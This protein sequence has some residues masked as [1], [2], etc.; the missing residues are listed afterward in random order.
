MTDTTST[1]TDADTGADTGVPAA[2]GPEV[3]A[4]AAQ[5]PRMEQIDPSLL[6]V[7]RNVRRDAAPDKTLIESVRDLGV[8]VPIVAVRTET[9]IRVRYGHRRTHAAIQAGQPTVPVWVFDTDH[10]DRDTGSEVQRYRIR[11]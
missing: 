9:G 7:D 2:A 8:L 11:R 1:T 3:A 5:G 4:P 6:L 10:A